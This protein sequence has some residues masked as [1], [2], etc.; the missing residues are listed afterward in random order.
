MG[1]G[2]GVYPRP[3][4]RIRLQ[5]SHNEWKSVGVILVTKAGFI[6]SL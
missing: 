6:S 5:N 4:A 1:E 3:I 2:D